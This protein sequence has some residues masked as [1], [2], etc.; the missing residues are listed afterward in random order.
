MAR[1]ATFTAGPGKTLPAREYYVEKGGNRY[2]VTVADLPNGPYA[3]RE[4]LAQTLAE[5]SKKGQVR[6]RADVELGLGRPGGQLNI[7]EPNR[8]Q[9]RASAYSAHHRLAVTQ[10]SPVLGYTP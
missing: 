6:T 1:D 5:L 9:L 10:V 7:L 4:L 2:S 3:D 8:R